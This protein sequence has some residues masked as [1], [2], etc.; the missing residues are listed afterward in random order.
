MVDAQIENHRAGW[1]IL[2]MEFD[3]LCGKKVAQI[4]A[5]FVMNDVEFR[6]EFEGMF[7]KF[8]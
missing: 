2:T 5:V 7:G 1:G 4:V 3:R 6:D 8:F